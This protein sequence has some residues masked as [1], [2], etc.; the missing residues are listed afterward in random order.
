MSTDSPI[1]FGPLYWILTGHKPHYNHV[2]SLFGFLLADAS[3][4]YTV[5]GVISSTLSSSWDWY[6]SCY[7]PFSMSSAK[8]MTHRFQCDI[9]TTVSGA[10]RHPISRLIILSQIYRSIFFQMTITS[11]LSFW[12]FLFFSP[13][14]LT[15][16]PNRNPSRITRSIFYSLDRTSQ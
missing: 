1:R 11:F 5:A 2:N 6:W 9:Q 13:F 8:Q 10:W 3:L 15:T 4:P 12:W 16:K 14:C 7:F